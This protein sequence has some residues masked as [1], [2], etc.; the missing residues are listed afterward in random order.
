MEASVIDVEVV[1]DV[2]LVVNVEVVVNV[3]GEFVFF[4]VCSYLRTFAI[5][6]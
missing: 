2:E 1:I 4:V 6:Y 3:V 5:T